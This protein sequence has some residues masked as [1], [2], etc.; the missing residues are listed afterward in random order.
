[1]AV[2]DVAMSQRLRA[3]ILSPLASGEVV[4]FEDGLM[5][6]DDDG[7]LESVGPFEPASDVVELSGLVVP[8][9]VDAHV[10]YPQTR[11]IGSASGPLL[12]WLE[13]TVFPEEAR[14]SEEAYAADV[15]REFARQCLKSGTTSVLSFSTSNERATALCFEELGRAGLRATVGLTLMDQYCPKELAVAAPDAI[16]AMRRLIAKYHGSASGRLAFAITPR[17]AISCS[18][19]LMRAAAELAREAELLV[20]THVS[21]NA[22][23]GKKTLEIHPFAEDYLGVYEA[24]G[25]V[26]ERTVFAHA[27]HFS[28]SEWRRIED[29]GASIA[30]CPD[31]NF[32]LGSGM[33][34]LRAALARGIGVGLGSDVGAGRSFDLRRAASYAYDAA[35]L[36]GAPVDAETL[37]RL[38]TLGG[39]TALGRGRELGSLEAGKWADFVVIERPSGRLSKPDAVRLATFGGELAPVLRTYVAGRAV[40]QTKP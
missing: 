5:V 38:A 33:M 12:T 13:E 18:A 1:M 22:D 16:S 11:V 37:F 4:F 14:F 30:H 8:G 27:I 36:R 35:L 20:Q 6:I 15:A 3:P 19:P 24:M 7:R 25:L 21:E 26:T 9:F 31:S 40:F 17:F 10:H 39:A 23:E 34:P 32:F 29:S 28:E 2:Q